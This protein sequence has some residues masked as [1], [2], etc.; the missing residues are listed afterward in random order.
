MDF[1][2]DADDAGASYAVELEQQRM[3]WAAHA[4]RSCSDTDTRARDLL[5]RY[6]A[7]IRDNPTD[8]KYRIFRLGNASFSRVW[9]DE[10]CRELLLVIGA[11]VG[12]THVTLQG[13]TGAAATAA[14][15]SRSEGAGGGG[16][17][18]QSTSG[19]GEGAA[20]G[21]GAG[22]G[23][24]ADGAVG[25]DDAL[26][27]VKTALDLLRPPTVTASAMEAEGGSGQYEGGPSSPGRNTCH[28]CGTGPLRSCGFPPR[29]MLMRAR[30][31]TEGCVCTTCEM[32]AAA[33]SFMVC[34]GCYNKGAYSSVHP[35]MHCFHAL[36][37]GPN[38][39][40]GC[41]GG[42]G[43]GGRRGGG[44]PPPPPPGTNRRWQ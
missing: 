1:V 3:L 19:S 14:T 38:D 16:E 32:D 11:T 6:L 28:L 12:D 2:A 10:R 22:E 21:G 33:P 15:G 44:A 20:G 36:G 4:V 9:A 42:G 24:R 7:N 26:A 39:D 23:K 34:G 8:P 17:V 31:D 5:L 13:G 25:A 40:G 37:W 29:G 27:A 35:S 30:Q 43:W 41:G 18:V